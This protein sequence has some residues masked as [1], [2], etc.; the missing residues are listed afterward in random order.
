MPTATRLHSSNPTRQVDGAVPTAYAAVRGNSSL[1]IRPG[2]GGAKL[3]QQKRP[4]H[5]LDLMADLTAAK[6]LGL[7]I[8]PMITARADELIE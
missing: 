5:T 1:P 8:P 6:A 3:L 7:T 4:V 2:T